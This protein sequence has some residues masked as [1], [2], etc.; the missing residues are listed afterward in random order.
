MGPFGALARLRA[1]F[2]DQFTPTDRGWVYRR[3]GHGPALPLGDEDH[4]ALTAGFARALRW[5]FWSGVAGGMVLGGIAEWRDLPR[6]A[7]LAVFAVVWGG[8]MWWAWSAP[9]RLLDGRAPVGR[10]LTGGEVRRHGL[11]TLPWS[12]LAAG[13]LLSIGLAVRVLF[14]PDPFGP[15]NRGYHAWAAG[16][17]LVFAGFAVAKI[18]AR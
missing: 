10:A 13:A 9:G 7:G 3:G 5:L 11:R 8:A 16:L 14:E 15:A 4:A 12:T 1:R 18:R 6:W 17:L 2:E